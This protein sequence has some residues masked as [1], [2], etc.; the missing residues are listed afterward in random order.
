MSAQDAQKRWE[1]E[2]NVQQADANA[3]FKYDLAEQQAIQKERPWTKDP[4]YFKQWVHLCVSNS[5]PRAVNGIGYIVYR[6][7]ATFVN[8]LDRSHPTDYFEL[9]T[10]VYSISSIA[11]WCK[12]SCMTWKDTWLGHYLCTVQ[13]FNHID[14]TSMRCMLFENEVSGA[15][16]PIDRNQRS[17]CMAHESTQL[18]WVLT[19]QASILMLRKHVLYAQG[20]IWMHFPTPDWDGDGISQ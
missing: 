8:R 3:I 12:G 1:L 2:N 10:W 5:L 13:G 20:W 6:G 14:I 16:Y 11:P 4:H 18:L 9:H 17:I 15:L 19:R 7:T